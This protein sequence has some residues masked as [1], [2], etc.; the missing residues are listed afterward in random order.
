MQLTGHMWIIFLS[1][2][3]GSVTA[4]AN[5]TKPKLDCLLLN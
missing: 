2:S 3:I 5:Q 4:K 1:N